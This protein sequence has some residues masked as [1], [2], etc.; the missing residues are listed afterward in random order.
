MLQNLF[1]FKNLLHYSC[2]LCARES[3]V[4]IRYELV[5]SNS[6]QNVH[7]LFLKNISK[8]TINLN[9]HFDIERLT[10]AQVN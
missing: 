8:C 4:N 3:N 2:E 6:F 10:L 7:F 5:Q 1:V 9:S